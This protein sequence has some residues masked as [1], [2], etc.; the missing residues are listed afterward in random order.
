MFSIFLSILAIYGIFNEDIES[1]LLFVL[2]SSLILV[3]ASS[4]I[5]YLQNKF[6]LIEEY[7]TINKVVNILGFISIIF[8]IGTAVLFMI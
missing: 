7:K 8:C 6:L 2:L 4:I 1:F 3:A 5:L